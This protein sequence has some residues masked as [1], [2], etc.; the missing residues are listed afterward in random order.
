MVGQTQGAAGTVITGAGLIV[1]AVSQQASATVPA[2]SVI[3]Q[4]PAPGT[5]VGPG[6]PVDLVVSLGPLPVTVPNL[7]G[8][9]QSTAVT[10]LQN[11]GLNATVTLSPYCTG[12]TG[13]VGR[14]T[15]PQQV[16]THP[17][18]S[19][20]VPGTVYAQNRA[21]AATAGARYFC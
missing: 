2:G 4:T 15:H 20:I 12:G 21:A 7:F 18:R 10:T 16:V 11:L 14:P 19:G 13:P 9:L 3:S 17:Y 6:S 5:L 8:L 1:G